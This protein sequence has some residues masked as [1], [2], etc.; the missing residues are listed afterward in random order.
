MK[1][2]FLFFLAFLF[3]VGCSNHAAREANINNEQVSTTVS[4]TQPVNWLKVHFLD[5]GQGDSILVQF[6]N[7]KNMLVDAGTNESASTIIN[8]LNNNGIRKLDYLVGTHPHED[9]IGSLDAVLKNF[10]IGEV[11]MPKAT[12]NTQT[13]RDVLAE[14]K[15]KGLQVMTAKAG[16]CVI[17]DGGLSVNI[18]GPC[19]AAYESLNNFSAVIKIKYGDVAFLLMGDAEALSE[20]EILATGADVRAQ[21]LKVGHHGSQSST[22]LDFLKAVNPE[23]A[24]ISV[25]AGNDY[26]LP[27]QAT[28]NKLQKAGI[29]V[30]R[31]DQTGT[32]VISTDG[33]KIYR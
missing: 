31:T 12:T 9:H 16:V 26:H 4:H 21:V 20:K 13:F 14:L 28:L 10:E 25:G 22:S 6:P 17:D 15:N 30:L 23:L 7:G 2:I 18:L 5:V 32:I 8:Y 19:G 29:T 33:R 11:L 3:L 1:R 24:V 27:H